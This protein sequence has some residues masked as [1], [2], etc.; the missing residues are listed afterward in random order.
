[1]LLIDEVLGVGDAAFRPKARAV[2]TE[3]IRSSET[4]VIVSHNEQ[5]LREYCDRVAWIHEGRLRMLD[6][7]DAVVAAYRQELGQGAAGSAGGS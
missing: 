3:R 2:I 5:T 7:A 1:M 6:T 4:V